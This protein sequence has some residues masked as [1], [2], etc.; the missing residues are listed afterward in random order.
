MDT[1]TTVN[2][3]VLD[4]VEMSVA[5]AFG[6]DVVLDPHPETRATSTAPPRRIAG[7]ACMTRTMMSPHIVHCHAVFQL[8][9]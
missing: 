3:P 4:V 6:V 2:E 8:A 7:L 9:I 1:A 5:E